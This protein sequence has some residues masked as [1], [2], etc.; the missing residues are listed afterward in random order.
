M[1]DKEKNVL[2]QSLVDEGWRAMRALLDE[3]LPLEKKHRRPFIWWWLLGVG[4]IVAGVALFLTMDVPS[5]SPPDKEPVLEHTTITKPIAQTKTLEAIAI[6]SKAM[7][8]MP[9]GTITQ[10][11]VAHS[12]PI[13]DRQF[14]IRQRAYKEAVSESLTV[15]SVKKNE[16][17]DKDEF[18][19]IDT[20]KALPALA[21]IMPDEI[22]FAPKETSPLDIEI[23]TE[24]R[25]KLNFYISAFAR[26][27]T[28][29]VLWTGGAVE[30]GVILPIAAKWDVSAGIAYG[31]DIM[32]MKSNTAGYVTQYTDISSGTLDPSSASLI[33]GSV[34]PNLSNSVKFPYA[35][36]VALDYT[37]VGLTKAFYTGISYISIPV[38]LNYHLSPRFFAQGGIELTYFT[39]VV[40]IENNSYSF[41]RSLGLD[42]Y[43]Q[44]DMLEESSSVA[45]IGYS[46]IVGFSDLDN[47]PVINY[48]VSPVAPVEINRWSVKWN[49]GVGYRINTH[50]STTLHVLGDI[51]PVSTGSQ[52]IKR[53]D[54]MELGLGVKRRF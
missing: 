19:P 37:G 45:N 8:A 49:V 47:N 14:D 17:D 2:N 13:S 6:P 51:S 54:W 40:N 21:P 15:V 43:K 24:K 29:P 52:L 42:S 9:N 22:E 3:E 28:K 31:R 1:L 50:W 30:A 16:E 34:L 27:V 46:A 10:H 32:R 41:Y 11:K 36:N 18:Q 12:T 38:S 53:I 33:Q 4:A 44:A 20:E 35:S 25:R 48:D 39:K 7:E 5:V 23:I 26:S